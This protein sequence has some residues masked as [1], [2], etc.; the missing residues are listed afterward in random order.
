MGE[1][2]QSRR[3]E[4]WSVQRHETYVIMALVGMSMLVVSGESVSWGG[5]A[6][7]A[8]GATIGTM[9]K[10]GSDG[11]EGRNATGD[12]GSG[13]RLDVP[14]EL[15]LSLLA[16]GLIAFVLVADADW[17]FSMGEAGSMLLGPSLGPLCVIAWSR[18]VGSD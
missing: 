6:G 18:T 10:E 4:Q 11:G 1:S 14:D 3:R 15:E 16:A 13:R 12:A 17:L 5:V 8:V 9:L 7:G 2:A